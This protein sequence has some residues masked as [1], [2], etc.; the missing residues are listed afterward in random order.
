MTQYV[1]T[2]SSMNLNDPLALYRAARQHMQDGEWEKGLDVVRLLI[3]LWPDVPELQAMEHELLGKLGQSPDTYKQDPLYKQAVQS[4]QKRDYPASLALIDQLLQRYPQAGRLHVL[5]DDVLRNLGRVKAKRLSK[6]LIGVLAMLNLTLVVVAVLF[7][8]YLNHPQPLAQLV[9]P[10]LEV[11]YAPHYLFSIYGLDK[12]IGVGVSP[13]GDRIYVTEMGGGR[14]IKAF[15]REG[16]PSGAFE[17]PNIPSAERAPVYLAVDPS[18]RVFVSDREQH[19]VYIFAGD[20]SFLEML[21]GPEMSLTQYLDG[22]NSAGQNIPSQSGQ[23][24]VYNLLESTLFYQAADGSQQTASLPYYP[25]WAPLGVRFTAQG[26]LLLTDVA[27]DKNAVLRITLPAGAQAAA[28]KDFHPQ[29][30]SFGA[31]GDGNAQFLF[32]NSAVTDS[33][34]RVYVSDGNNRRISVWDSQGSFLYN[35]G[36]GTDENG[37]S[38]PRGLWIDKRDRLYVVDAVGQD[39]KVYDVSQAEPAFLFAF[40]DFGQE[41]GLFNYPNDIAMDGSGRLYIVDRE[42]NRIQVWSY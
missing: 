15:D 3:K 36:S 26:E 35:F 41:D 17:P 6:R 32:P 14:M 5:R 28:W 16:K 30:R 2:D 40:G 25:E 1:Q 23:G 7:I 11:N 8:R 22:Q 18:G 34:G 39:V 12:P 27:K 31:S 21:V 38:L 42:N 19:A 29:V 4:L 20:G 10:Q 13:E 9:A 33:Q 37:L 24:F